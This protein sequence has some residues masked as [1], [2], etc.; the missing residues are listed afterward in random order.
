MNNVIINTTLSNESILQ[1]V[2]QFNAI[3]P[4]Q[5]VTVYISSEGGEI[6]IAE[7]IMDIIEHCSAKITFVAS[8]ELCS[9]AFELFFN[10]KCFDKR[11]LPQTIG[12]IHQAK[13][14]YEYNEAGKPA[15]GYS[16]I[17]RSNLKRSYLKGIIYLQ[18]LGLTEKEIEDYKSGKDIFF[19]CARL[20]QFL[21]NSQHG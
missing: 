15:D 16:K 3:D 19:D 21:K 5:P 20:K 14:P 10:T 9:S 18:K 12:M 6:R 13:C 4:N 17:V 7:T 11:I 1:I 8:G 2:Q